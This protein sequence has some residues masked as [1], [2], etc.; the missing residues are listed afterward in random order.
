[1]AEATYIL[2]GAESLST[3]ATRKNN[4]AAVWIRSQSGHWA[5]ATWGEA[6]A[7]GTMDRNFGSA[8]VTVE[9][10]STIFLVGEFGQTSGL[11]SHNEAHIVI[12]RA[13]GTF[14]I[15]KE[16]GEL[17]TSS[18]VS[19]NEIIV[20][21][22]GDRIHLVAS[23]EANQNIYTTF[24]YQFKISANNAGI[25]VANTVLG[26]TW[27]DQS[28]FLWRF[29]VWYSDVYGTDF[30]EEFEVCFNDPGSGDFSLLA[31]TGETMYT[32]AGEDIVTFDPAGGYTYRVYATAD[33]FFTL[34]FDNVVILQG[35]QWPV[36]YTVDLTGPAYG[37]GAHKLRLQGTNG[38]QR[39]ASNPAGIA[40]VIAR[41]RPGTESVEE[42]VFWTAAI[43]DAHGGKNRFACPWSGDKGIEIRMSQLAVRG[44]KKTYNFPG[45]MYGAADRH[46]FNNDETLE[47]QG[48][49]Y[50]YT[51]PGTRNVSWYQPSRDAKN[52][53]Y[54][55]NG[56]EYPFINFRGELHPLQNYLNVVRWKAPKA[57]RVRMYGTCYD[58]NS[59]GG[60]GV[61]VWLG[62]MAVADGPANKGNVAEFIVKSQSTS[63]RSIT[64]YDGYGYS[65]TTV[66]A[67]EYIQ[68]NKVVDVRKGETFYFVVG[69]DTDHSY[70]TT[71][72]NWNMYYES[73]NFADTN[74]ALREMTEDVG[75]YQVIMPNYYPGKGQGYQG[76]LKYFANKFSDRGALSDVKMS[77]W[78]DSTWVP[79]L[80][81][82]N[83]TPD[84]AYYAD[85]GNGTLDIRAAFHMG[86]AQW[87]N[88]G[89]SG[90]LLSS[91][92]RLHNYAPP[93]GVTL[94]DYIETDWQSGPQAQG[95]SSVRTLFRSLIGGL[96]GVE[97]SFTWKTPNSN[98]SYSV[99]LN[100]DTL[101]PTGLT[102]VE[103]GMTYEYGY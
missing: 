47:F 16:T 32:E 89:Q 56:T 35:N 100:D 53:H 92:F 48:W 22:P 46:G 84:T 59:G 25:I 66:V 36:T 37:F 44:G 85:R 64:S 71:Q 1:M 9:E 50:G 49:K 52:G 17:K 38:G 91:Q 20:L 82:Q 67:Q 79:L 83:M 57:G 74:L 24:S 19:F 94:R 40:C 30:D 90:I 28:D 18:V 80:Q 41:L 33:D 88:R 68:W 62:R 69:P 29:G 95:G 3:Y 7:L 34:S 76:Q 26:N 86:G 78:I 93:P 12:Q 10:P 23:F 55:R 72:L 43:A 58:A 6:I 27:K 103:R 98:T 51:T 96:Y 21:Q 81:R 31:E 63:D 102:F 8:P 42:Y 70:D 99:M 65:T 77:D 39:T 13:N 101:L 61:I 4:P 11:V 5:T 2:E 87:W 75:R 97:A 73:I 14:E 60:N 15:V 45:N 54:F